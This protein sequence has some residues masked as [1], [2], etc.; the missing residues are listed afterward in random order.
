MFQLSQAALSAFGV[1]IG[2]VVVVAELAELTCFLTQEA[3]L[4]AQKA[5]LSFCG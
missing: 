5:A 4:S 1:F 3:A 2:V